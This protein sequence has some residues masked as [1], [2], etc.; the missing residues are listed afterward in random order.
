MN[1]TKSSLIR[2]ISWTQN[3]IKSQDHYS[4]SVSLSC[5][6]E[7]SFNTLLGGLVT[8]VIKLGVIVIAIATN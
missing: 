4:K 7:D 1:V 6:G 5:N 2:F 3:K 8:V